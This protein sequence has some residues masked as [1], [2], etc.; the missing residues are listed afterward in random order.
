MCLQEFPVRSSDTASAVSRQ[1]QLA[2]VSP[3]PRR[4]SEYAELSRQV[5]EAGLLER[6]PGYYMRKIAVTIGLLAA[7]WTAFVLLG[8][9][10]WQLA[11]AA[12]LAVIFTQIGFLG[13]DA[14]HRGIVKAGTG[15]DRATFGG[16]A[17]RQ[18]PPRTPAA[19]QPPRSPCASQ[20][21][22]RCD[23]PTQRLPCPGRYS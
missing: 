18:P 20:E 12:F 5:K 16:T 22:S 10:W 2:P 8:D 11:V 21:S 7:G 23:L 13:H 3:A 6:R 17:A 14:G 4:G 1:I 15:R 9:S 19:P